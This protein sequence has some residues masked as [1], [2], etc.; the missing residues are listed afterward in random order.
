MRHSKYRTVALVI[1]LTAIG[2]IR[3]AAAQTKESFDGFKFV[4]KAGNIHK[5]DDYRDLYQMIGS[6]T[7]LDPKGNQMHIV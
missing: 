4:D 6:W 5:R 7:V 2:F 3:E 1:S